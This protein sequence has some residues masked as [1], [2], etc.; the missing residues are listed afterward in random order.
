MPRRFSQ[1]KNKAQAD[2]KMDRKAHSNRKP[3]WKAVCFCP[4]PSS[5][6]CTP[7]GSFLEIFSLA[8]KLCLSTACQ[9]DFF[10]APGEFEGEFEAADKLWLRI[11]RVTTTD[12]WH[13]P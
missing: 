9:V 5:Y 12:S 10:P 13:L 6:L 3:E 11:S 7:A 8:R 4:A 2:Q 1:K